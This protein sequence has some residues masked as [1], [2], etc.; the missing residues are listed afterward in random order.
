MNLITIEEIIKATNGKKILS[1]TTNE[2][3]S[4]SIDSR[5]ADNK[6]LFV[7]IIGETLNGHNFANSAY[8]NGCR[9][10]L[11]QE[12]HTL[13][14]DDSNI[15]V[16]EVTNTENALGDIAHYYKSKFDIPFIGITGSVGKTTTRDMIYSVISSKFNT[17]KNQKNFNNQIGVPLTLFNLDESYECAVVE[18]GMSGF[19]EIEHLANIVRPKI[20][21]I[22]NIGQSHIE[23]LGSQLGI[24]KAKMEITANFD[25]DSILIINGDDESLK[26]IK[27][28]KY[29]YS[30]RT[31][32]FSEDCTIYCT[33]YA[34]N[35]NKTEFS[36]I[37]N[38]KAYNFIIPAIGEHNIY[39]AMAAISVGLALDISIDNIR[40]GL[41]HLEITGMRLEVEKLESLTVINDTYNASPDS[42]KAALKTLSMY[43][44][45][46][47]AILGDMFEMGD[48][49]KDGH[50][51][52]GSYSIDKTD[53]LITIGELSKY[54]SDRAIKDGFDKN[55]VYH[56]KTKD[57]ENLYKLIQNEDTVL[58][59]ASRGMKLETII[60][61]LKNS[62][63]N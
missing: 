3:L 4:I 59:K 7:P 38:N 30:I 43:P 53:V 45:R 58:V 6:S 12:G 27:N 23:R 13:N 19:N 57:E 22:S 1:S 17:L 14:I 44:G 56:F 36:C 61:K 48:F 26:A 8:E 52:V 5:E 10:F 21:V 63:I 55:N 34:I 20:G 15:T 31:F 47:V 9:V 11:K 32:G 54:I 16:I 46:K 51:T 28:E 33:D 60:D 18:M 25:E 29:K 42:M 24:F 40:E 35:E 39:N 50:E 41:S 37:I 2:I 62:R 49:A